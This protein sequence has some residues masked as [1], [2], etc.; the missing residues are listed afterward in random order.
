MPYGCV[1]EKP[2]PGFC[3]SQ[4]LR[5]HYN[6]RHAHNHGRGLV[7]RSIL[8]IGD[9]LALLAVTFIGFASH[10]ELAG[11]FLPRMAASLVPL[12]LGWFLLAPALGLFGGEASLTQW[13]RPAFVMLFAGP[14]AALLRSLA[15]GSSVIPS[16]AIV[17]MVTSA[18]AL[19]LWRLAY[20]LVAR[21]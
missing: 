3:V 8:I 13:W 18:V 7:K 12:Y 6:V 4:P 21:R 9:I 15:L 19:T 2:T 11:S 14:F 20:G 17:L 10:G 5:A 1:G 16:F